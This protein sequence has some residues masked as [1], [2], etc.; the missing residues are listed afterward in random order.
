MTN[1]DTRIRLTRPPGF[2]LAASS[3][4][5]MNFPASQ[6]GETNAALNL[7]FALDSTWEPVGVRVV[8]DDD[9]LAADIIANPRHAE[10]P[11]TKS[12]I[13]RILNLSIE[14]AGFATI[15]ERDPVVAALQQRYPGLRPVQFPT[16]YE[17]A[18]WTIIGHRIRITQAAI[19]KGRIAAQ[20]GTRVA[21]PNGQTLDAFPTPDTLLG[22]DFVPG[23]TARTIGYLHTLADAALAGELAARR[24]LAL[25]P[26]ESLKALQRLPGIGPFSAELI[27]VRGAGH[28]D[29]FPTHE[30]R[31]TKAMTALYGTDSAEE[32]A[33]IAEAWQPFRSWVALLIRSWLEDET[34][35]IA[36]GRSQAEIPLSV[37]PPGTG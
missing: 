25:S 19:I 8:E 3:R 1:P 22:I 13:E 14:A 35:E 36:R 26:T 23:L 24:L 20:F 2:S 11:A 4:F 27:L 12:N 31:L 32:H 17:A 21:F 15:G 10:P 33:R 18:A 34:H 6:G 7:A 5:V 9:G 28:P 29:L 16:P 37:L 30:P